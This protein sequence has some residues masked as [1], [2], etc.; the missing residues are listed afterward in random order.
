MSAR[1]SSVLGLILATTAPLLLVACDGQSEPSSQQR[2]SGGSPIAARATTRAAE[3]SQPVSRDGAGAKP[4]YRSLVDNQRRRSRKRFSPCDL[5]KRSDVRAIL[6]EAILEPYEAPQGPTCIF[7]TRSRGKLV[8]LAVQAASIA[9]LKRQLQRVRRTT[10]GAHRAYCG[11]L[12]QPVL[13]VPLRR[14]RVLMIA[15][16]CQTARRFAS[17]A[18][19]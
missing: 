9:Q 14:H 18:L 13:Y 15:A 6:G 12:G 16:P 19:R 3:P 11:V 5:V 4:D 7:R 17:A 2:G 10:I 1:R 8:T